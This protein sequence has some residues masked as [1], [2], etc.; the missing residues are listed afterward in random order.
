MK[1]VKKSFHIP[2]SYTFTAGCSNPTTVISLAPFVSSCSSPLNYV[3]N[4]RPYYQQRKFPQTSSHS[5]VAIHST[6][7]EDF[8]TPPSTDKNM[9]DTSKKNPFE[10][11]VKQQTLQIFDEVY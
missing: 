6:D 11:L 1:A 4:L 5:I 7:D 3:G 8:V 2:P 9:D 10:Q